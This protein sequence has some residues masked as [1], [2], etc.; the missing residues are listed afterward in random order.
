M[1][2]RKGSNGAADEPASG[3]GTA[4]P[5]L[6]LGDIDEDDA[7]G[8]NPFADIKKLRVRNRALIE[9]DADHGSITIG[10]PPKDKF[11][12][13]PDDEEW[14]LP[15]MVWSDPQDGR[16]V[17][18][19]GEPLW[20]LSDLQGVLR[21][22][23]LAPWMLT[24]GVLGLWPISTKD[25]NGGDYRETALDAVREA[26]KD[27]RRVQSDQKERCWHHF[28]PHE[29]LPKRAWPADLTPEKFYHKAFG[30]NRVVMNTDHPLIRR[31]RG[32]EA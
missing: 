27:W 15:A 5:P 7:A 11:F 30:K 14:Y 10:P 12:I 26:R 3:N 9:G 13:C 31:L 2:A 17:F 23:M 6:G 1:T 20:E 24:S 29:P 8:S 16:K 32:L 22:V 28:P 25:F 18:Y 21:S 4:P 19:I